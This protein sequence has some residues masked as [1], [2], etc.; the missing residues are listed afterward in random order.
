MRSE[1]LKVILSSSCLL[2]PTAAA[3]IPSTAVCHSKEEEEEDDV[4]KIV[5]TAEESLCPLL[6]S[7]L[8]QNRASAGKEVL[9]VAIFKCRDK[10]ADVRTLAFDLLQEVTKMLMVARGQEH[11]QQQKHQLSCQEL[12]A[13]TRHLVQVCRQEDARDTTS[14]YRKRD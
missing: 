11:Q 10:V 2:L 12:L 5:T 13:V 9:R 8:L 14:I 4:D 6:S 3:G 1:A 7:L